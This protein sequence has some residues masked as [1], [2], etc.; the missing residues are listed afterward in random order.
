MESQE[1]TLK[2]K[3]RCIL[4]LF[5]G[6]VYFYSFK[7]NKLCTLPD[8][9]I[10]TTTTTAMTK[11]TAIYLYGRQNC[12]YAVTLDSRSVEI[13]LSLPDS[14]LYYKDNLSPDTHFIEITANPHA[15]STER[16][17]FDKAVYTELGINER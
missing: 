1:K 6:Q 13:P 10:L 4:P 8:I 5:L 3:S 14:V 7:V 15:N 12:S 11:G 9:P 17:S 2:A 16:L